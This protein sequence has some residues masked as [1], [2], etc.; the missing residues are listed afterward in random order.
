MPFYLQYALCKNQNEA[1]SI[2]KQGFEPNDDKV[3]EEFGNFCSYQRDYI[4]IAFR[5]F[6]KITAKLDIFNFE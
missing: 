1:N 3:R 4:E 6:V 5:Q 2:I